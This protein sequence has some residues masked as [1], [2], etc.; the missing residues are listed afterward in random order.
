[1][2]LHLLF[3]IKMIELSFYSSYNF[4]GFVSLYILCINVTFFELMSFLACIN[5]PDFGAF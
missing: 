2:R 3:C 4:Y 1:M 5:S